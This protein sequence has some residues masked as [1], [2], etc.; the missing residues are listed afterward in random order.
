MQLSRRAFGT[1]IA[2][3][4]VQ[5]T[6]S[7]V[8]PETG[9]AP[10]RERSRLDQ[11]LD[12]SLGMSTPDGDLSAPGEG[13]SAFLL[14]DRDTSVRMFQRD[15]WSNGIVVQSAR[16][17]ALWSHDGYQVAG[18]QLSVAVHEHLGLVVRTHGRS[19][20]EVFD[21][22]TGALISA[23]MV[24]HVVAKRSDLFLL[25]L[26]FVG[27]YGL[28]APGIAAVRRSSNHEVVSFGSEVDPWNMGLVMAHGGAVSPD[29]RLYATTHQTELVV[30]DAADDAV[31]MSLALPESAK[32][33]FTRDGAEVVCVQSDGVEALREQVGG[34]GPGWA[35]T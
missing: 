31:L 26:P 10:V 8:N 25:A 27:P 30:R 14:S 7:K 12:W 33:F 13:P 19:R 22:R 2:G 34:T 24:R 15:G 17:G 6:M 23:G 20:E 29:G 1:G 5:L 16:G 9:R 18:G 32:P 3:F 4:V 35:V 28:L 21:L 11:E